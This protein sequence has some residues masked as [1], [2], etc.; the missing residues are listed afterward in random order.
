M[1]I[2]RP[3]EPTLTRFQRMQLEQPWCIYCGGTTPGTSI[4]HVPPRIAFNFKHRPKGMEYMSCDACA[5]GSRKLDQVAAFFVR[6]Y[7]TTPG[8][9][10]HRQEIRK[11][12]RAIGNNAREVLEELQIERDLRGTRHAVHEA[13]PVA[14]G[15]FTSGP[16]SASYLAAFGARLGLALHY[17]KTRQSCQRRAASLSIRNQTTK[18][19]KAA[20]LSNSSQCWE[21]RSRW[22][23]ASSVLLTNS[24]MPVG[25]KATVP[26]RRTSWRSGCPLPFRL[27]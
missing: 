5:E 17:E 25:K 22:N 4:D 7:S 23:K 15:I 12:V 10:Q 8:N 13:L 1:K 18:L 21:R 3:T 14:A 9:R 11:I 2:N 26:G 20:S 19:L 27:L 24:N 16:I 6:L